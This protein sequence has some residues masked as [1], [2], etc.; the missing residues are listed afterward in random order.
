MHLSISLGKN[1]KYI[2]SIKFVFILLIKNNAYVWEV[3]GNAI[4]FPF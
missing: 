1:T 4:N 2:E 3:G